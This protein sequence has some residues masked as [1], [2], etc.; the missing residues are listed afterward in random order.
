MI[1]VPALVSACLAVIGL[2]VAADIFDRIA[3]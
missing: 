2:A 3:R 1:L